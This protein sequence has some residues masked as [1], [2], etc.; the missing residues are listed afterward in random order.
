M[1]RRVVWWV[2]I[3]ATALSCVGC[4]R[5][6]TAVHPTTSGPPPSSCV[7]GPRTACLGNADD[8]RTVTVPVGGTV[9]VSLSSAG[10]RWGAPA[11]SDRAV[12]VVVA[13]TGGG[14]AVRVRYVARTPGTARLSAI[15][16]PVCVAGGACPQFV[17]FWQVTV[18]VG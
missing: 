6:T 12:L 4:V 9:T 11:V 17:T 3:V 18:V 14:G 10:L 7:P 2:A 13:S 15:G 8:G 1:R 16:T 5:S